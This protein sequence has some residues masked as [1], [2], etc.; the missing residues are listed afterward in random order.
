VSMRRQYR[1]DLVM[2]NAEY[3]EELPQPWLGLRG[4]SRWLALHASSAVSQER[5][6]TIIR[7]IAA[8]ATR[9]GFAAALRWQCRNRSPSLPRTS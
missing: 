1:Q 7:W 2:W 3:C 9:H 5:E 8:G 6:H 4:H